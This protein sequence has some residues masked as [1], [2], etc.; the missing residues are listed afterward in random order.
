MSHVSVFESNMKDHSILRMILE[1]KGIRF[2]TDCT[3]QQYGKNNFEAK[4]VFKLPGWKYDIGVDED[5]KVLY[6][7]FGSDSNAFNHLNE[8]V[9][10]YNVSMVQ[11]AC[12]NE[13]LDYY[14]TEI[15]E[16]M[17]FVINM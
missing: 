8:I 11:N 1:N 12:M 14:T 4:T 3:A 13:G 16:G 9:Y 6:D 7:F 15:E 5:G 10:D 2:Q 17:K